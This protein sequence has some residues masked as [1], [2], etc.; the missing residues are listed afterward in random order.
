LEV[1]IK[2]AITDLQK[3]LD[4]PPVEYQVWRTVDRF[5]VPATGFTVG[6]VFFCQHN[7]PDVIREKKLIEDAIRG[8]QDCLDNYWPDHIE[9]FT[10][11]RISV[12]AGDREAAF[13]IADAELQMTMAVINYF[14]S[15]FTPSDQLPAI[16]LPGR[17]P[18]YAIYQMAD[19]ISPRHKFSYRH[20]VH[21]FSSSFSFDVL[22]IKGNELT[23]GAFMKLNQL[24][25]KP[26]GNEYVQRILTAVKWA[27]K[28]AAEE[29]TENA[30]L[31]SAVALESL[32]L[33]VKKSSD[34]QLSFKL[35][36]RVSYLL[37][38]N[39]E[40]RAKISNIVK[41]LYN[42]RSGMVHSGK[43][44]VPQ[45]DLDYVRQI[46]N[47]C[48]ILI[49]SSPKLSSVG[50]DDALEEWFDDVILGGTPWFEGGGAPTSAKT[51]T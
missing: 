12:R 29:N 51:P 3:K 8:K 15:F 25:L 13:A 41:G 44:Q 21:R 32:I 47:T 37:G 5:R 24:L 1:R 33:G 17:V 20:Q 7:H 9:H 27:G 2:N 6:K 40:A 50:T 10:L 34:Q 31:F 4:S 48:V 35:R 39:P 30:F 18:Q 45:I 42:L 22:D 14:A 28:S 43:T 36:L 23:K 49:L 11:C 38:N 16:C 26:S 19:Q 46:T